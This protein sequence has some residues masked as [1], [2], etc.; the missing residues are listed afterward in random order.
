MWCFA[1]VDMSVVSLVG[2]VVFLFLLG[3]WKSRREIAHLSRC[4]L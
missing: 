2:A 4:Q 3:E 1:Q